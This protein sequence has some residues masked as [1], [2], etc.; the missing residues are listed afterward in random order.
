MATGL[1]VYLLAVRGHVVVMRCKVNFVSR[2]NQDVLGANTL[3]VFIAVEAEGFGAEGG[4]RGL[5]SHLDE[6]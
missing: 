2:L 5:G 4:G 1:L 3:V 6:S